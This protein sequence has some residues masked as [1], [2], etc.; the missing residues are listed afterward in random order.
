VDEI[1]RAAARPLMDDEAKRWLDACA[2]L[3]T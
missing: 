1:D 2:K 3:A